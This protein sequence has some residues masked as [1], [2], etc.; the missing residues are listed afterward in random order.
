M[1]QSEP[2]RQTAPG[3]VCN[4]NRVVTARALV[5]EGPRR[6]VE[7]RLPLPAVGADDARLRVEAC[8]LCGTDHEQFGGVLWGGFPFIPG[9]EV[10]GVIEAIG[11]DATRRWGVTEGDRVAVE[12][13][14]SCGHCPACSSGEYRRCRTHGLADMYG[15]IDVGRPPGLWGGYATHQYLGPDALVHPVPAG[16]D[17]VLATLF[18]PLGAG[19]R[20]AATLPATGP[21]AVVAIL[22]PGIR[23]ICSLV[24]A[25]HAGAGF[26][27]LT[28]FGPRD[29]AR[30]E[31]ARRF[32]ADLTVDVATS[33]PA[34]ALKDAT[35]G[36]A[37]VV[38]DVTAK[39]PSA[40]AQAVA[41]ARPGGTIVVAGTRGSNETPGFIPDLLVYKELRVLGALG[42]DAAA[43][44]TALQLLATGVA[45]WT[46]LPREVT[47]FAGLESLLR[48]LAGDEAGPTP[49]HSVLVP[50]G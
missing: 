30:M 22:G 27:A 8:G 41:L 1:V 18:N 11:P 9:H 39:A 21:G 33:D 28:G 31:T 25:R 4:S 46:D 24:A 36:L 34:A 16:I 15:Y 14:Q 10:V 20:W 40:L 3:R 7:R 12:V 37:D 48:R 49:V 19:I 35:G 13:F 29:V 45:P 50:D 47:D 17:P 26:V 5:L 2:P 32:G 44:R 42:V 6:L 43:Y 38:I 23:G